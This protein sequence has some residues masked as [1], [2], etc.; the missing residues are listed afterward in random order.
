MGRLRR[1]LIPGAP[2][3]GVTGCSGESLRLKVRERQQKGRAN[4]AVIRLLARRLGIP[5]ASIGIVHG[6]GSRDKLVEVEG[7]SDEELRSGLG[8]AAH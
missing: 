5:R 7:F 1:H 8:P 6:A 2:E 4:E 3:E